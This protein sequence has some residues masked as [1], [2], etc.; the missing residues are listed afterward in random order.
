[1]SSS[2]QRIEEAHELVY[3][4]MKSNNINTE[5]YSFDLFFNHIA[6]KH[7]I[8]YDKIDFGP[9][10]GKYLCGVIAGLEKKWFIHVNN[11]LIITRQNF[12]LCHELSHFIWDCDF[13]SEKNTYQSLLGEQPDEFDNTEFLA[14]NAAGVIMLP[15]ICIKES[16]SKGLSSAE[17]SRKF[18]ISISALKTRLLQ[19]FMYHLNCPIDVILD[20]VVN[21]LQKNDLHNL[22]F[23]LYLEDF[24][25][26]SKVNRVFKQN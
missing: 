19:F 11:N 17:I 10:L 5:N 9:T 8:D 6:E 20:P 13:G 24:N 1:M 7:D 3:R 18:G 21:Y 15:D 2:Y 16:L 22:E 4:F 23:F 12:T 25:L 14:D 26:I